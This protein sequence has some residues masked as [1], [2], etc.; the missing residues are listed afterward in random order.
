MFHANLRLFHVFQVLEVDRT[1]N[2]LGLSMTTCF[3][4]SDR[5]VSQSEMWFH[6]LVWIN[7]FYPVVCCGFVASE[8]GNFKK[9][10]NNQY[11]QLRF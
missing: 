7:G 1:M 3:W 10:K 2:D 11:T 9:N 4:T 5:W 8:Q 6:T